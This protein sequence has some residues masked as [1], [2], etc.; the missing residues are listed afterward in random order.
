MKVLHFPENPS[1]IYLVAG[2]MLLASVMSIVDVGLSS[3]GVSFGLI[4]AVLGVMLAVP[5]LK[6]SWET[7]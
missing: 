1:G 7:T 5:T 4:T 2:V 3:G 6:L